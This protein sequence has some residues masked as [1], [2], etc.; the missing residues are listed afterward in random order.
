MAYLDGLVTSVG[1]A[2][3]GAGDVLVAQVEE[4]GR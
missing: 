4:D 1:C 3:S 2:G